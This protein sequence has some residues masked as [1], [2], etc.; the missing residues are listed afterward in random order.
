MTGRGWALF[1]A[2]GVIWGLPYLLIRVSMRE[3]APAFLVFVRTAGG[4]LL[5]APFA[6][7]RGALG[8]L[9]AHW[10][11]LVAL[12]LTELAVPWW[13]LFDAEKKLSSSLTG[14]LVAAVPIAGAVLARVTGTDR[15]DRRR[16]A[17]LALGVAGVAA[18][19]GFDVG[20]ADIWA[21]SSLL[22]VVVGYALGPWIM[23]R[24]LSGLPGPSVITAAL[25]LCAIVYA[26][27]ALVQR[28]QHALSAAVLAS[29]AGLTALC[30]A[31]AFVAFF[32]LVAEV[33]PMRS[34]VVTYIN[35]A[36]AVLLGV[37]VLGEPF[38]VATGVGFVLVLAGSFLATR[39]LHRAPAAAPIGSPESPSAG[40]TPLSPPFPG[41][42][43]PAPLNA[44]SATV[45]E[46]WH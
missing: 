7:R 46:P 21:A 1:I 43:I 33:G 20:R 40:P 9:L 35:P 6:V 42:I 34:T 28:P 27:V 45:P 10:K 26:P 16:A 39:P 15:L 3:V 8:S 31:V 29:M 25:A 41:E 14:L 13:F 18:L 22:F 30:T 5:L 11:A 38:G 44:S 2:M 32:A 23:A 24:Y 4:A 12:A 36:V 19:V 17:G 37:T